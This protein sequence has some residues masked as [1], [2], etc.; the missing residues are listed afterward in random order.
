MTQTDPDSISAPFLIV[1]PEGGEPVLC[2]LALAPMVEVPS[3]T[4]GPWLALQKGQPATVVAVARDSLAQAMASNRLSGSL[5]APAN[6]EGQ[7]CSWR[8]RNTKVVT[9]D[10]ASLYF[11]PSTVC[12]CGSDDE[13]RYECDDELRPAQALDE[14]ATSIAPGYRFVSDERLG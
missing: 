8:L 7:R 5:R 14:P 4:S 1:E 11:C 10:G 3:G 12:W 6:S 13:P 2:P 9:V